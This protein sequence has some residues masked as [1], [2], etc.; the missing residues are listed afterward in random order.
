MKGG[1]Q[2]D[3]KVGE[4]STEGAELCPDLTGNADL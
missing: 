3:L 1:T 2:E 4:A